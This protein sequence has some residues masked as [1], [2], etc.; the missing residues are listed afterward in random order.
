MN[1]FHHV[2]MHW[3][4]QTHYSYKKH[5]F[6]VEVY[7][8][9]YLSSNYK[10]HTSKQACRL[11]I[12]RQCL[13]VQFCYSPASQ[14]GDMYRNVRNMVHMMYQI[15]TVY[16]MPCVN[17]H[18]SMAWVIRQ[19]LHQHGAN[20]SEQHTAGFIRHLWISSTMKEDTNQSGVEIHAKI[21]CLCSSSL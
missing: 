5:S 21:M 4:F 12:V 10:L 15:H 16:H 14:H 18:C 17:K 6:I 8:S 11:K 19:M 9:N 7:T 13:V 2:P 1:S 3:T 20:L